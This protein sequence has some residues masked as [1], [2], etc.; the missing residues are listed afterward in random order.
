LEKTECRNIPSGFPL[1]CPPDV[2]APA[3]MRLVTDF[4][5]GQFATKERKKTMD[6]WILDPD[7]EP[8]TVEFS[9]EELERLEMAIEFFLDGYCDGEE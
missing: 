6:D 8:E 3:L 7:W 9:E 4:N 2:T 5:H 1:G